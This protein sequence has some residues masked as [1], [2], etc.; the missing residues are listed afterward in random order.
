VLVHVADGSLQLVC[1]LHPSDAYKIWH[2]GRSI[3]W[4]RVL[5]VCVH[6]RRAEEQWRAGLP[7]VL[8][9]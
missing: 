8:L 4:R 7:S 1:T 2:D 6:F 9:L 3:G 5:G